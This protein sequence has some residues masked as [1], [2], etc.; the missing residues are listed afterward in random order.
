MGLAGSFSLPVD[1]HDCGLTNND[2]LH[3][4]ICKLQTVGVTSVASAGRGPLELTVPAG[5]SEVLAVT[6]MADFDGRPGSLEFFSGCADLD[7]DD[8]YA[9]GFSG[10]DFG[11]DYVGRTHILSAPGACINSTFLTA[12]SNP[13]YQVGSGTLQSCAH[14]SA[15]TALCTSG[16][17]CFPI[18]TTPQ[19]T[20]D[21]LVL[22]SRRASVPITSIP[23]PYDIANVF[24]MNVSPFCNGCG[25][26]L[27][28]YFG[29]LPKPLYPFLSQPFILSPQ[30]PANFTQ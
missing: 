2:T 14:V 23:G 11:P 28:A 16:Y 22:D 17:G 29:Y 3:Q 26:P 9:P 27:Q 21:K 6:G 15:I 4:I 30:C 20:I 7:I 18:P 25:A 12:S 10:G 24:S 8:D 5:Y 13:P 1:D 19:D